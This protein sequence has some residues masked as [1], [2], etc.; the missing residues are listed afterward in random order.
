MHSPVRVLHVDPDTG[1]GASLGASLD[2]FEVVAETSAGDA[3][4]VLADG[5]AVA[6]LV[7][8]Y[9]LPDMDGT[10]FLRQVRTRFPDR[11][12]PFVLVTDAGSEAV[13]AE[14][15]NAGASGYVAKSDPDAAAKAAERVRHE[16][17]AVADR[18]G[19][20][21]ATLA[22]AMDDP[23]YVLDADGQFTYVNGAFVDLV[24]YGREELL[25]ATPALVKDEAAVE[26][27]ERNLARI[28]SS[29]GPDSLTFEVDIQARDG[30]AVTCEDHMGVLPYEGESFRGSLGVL[31]DVTA[32]KRRKRELARKRAFLER[33]QETA[34]VGGW[35]VDLRTET[36]RWTDEVYR[37]HGIS[38]E[39]DPTVEGA[40]DAYHPEDR[41]EIEAAL[42][43]LVADGEPFD[44]EARIYTADDEVRWVRARGTPWHE[45]GTMVGARGTFQDVTERVEYEHRLQRQRDD[46]DVLN[47]M[48]RHDIRNDLQV[49]TAHAET[50]RP[51]V[52]GDDAERVEKILS[53]AGNAIELTRS[54]RDLAEVM[55]QTDPD[56]E[57][58]PLRTVLESELE[59]VRETRP[60]AT[61][62]TEG[63]VPAVTVR[64]GE[65]L[66]SVFRN[67][68]KNAVQHNDTD[69]PEVTV[70]AT[71][72]DGT[73]EVAVADNGPGVP[74]E[75][76]EEIFGQGEKGLESSGT[77]IGLY[78]V[79]TLVERYGGDVRVEDNDPEGSV[80]VVRLPTDGERPG[81]PCESSTSPPN[82]GV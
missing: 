16:V 81:R 13:A 31:R 78:L 8:E 46:L 68:L 22:R 54:A 24:G 23:V 71:T 27:A 38:T 42:D 45:A 52:D 65:M 76:K 41:P 18:T 58:V 25:G 32:R 12:L 43:R 37:I 35:E 11:A 15:L 30:S 72:G 9:A 2:G 47:Q 69:D 20:R 63:T 26:T 73:V 77:G 55:R 44:L 60:D 67:L 39:Y 29:E 40:L 48:V 80:F 6:C 50:L 19:D 3:L 64:A 53:H 34:T 59:E 33:I 61:V 28:L 70:S 74:D 82:T 57:P 14:A 66:S 1:F 79:R 4:D 56:L 51:E 7:S 75:R 5:P 49:V 36:L 17:Q 10:E 62:T 21:F